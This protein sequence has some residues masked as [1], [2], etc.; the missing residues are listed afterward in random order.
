M[1]IA[2]ARYNSYTS[3]FSSAA[4]LSA[5]TFAEYQPRLENSLA[6]FCHAHAPSPFMLVKAETDFEHLTILQR[7]VE[8]LLPAG[9]LY[10]SRYHITPEQI[11]VTPAERPGDN[12]AAT[13]RVACAE[14]FES[15]QLLGTVRLG[16]S[17]LLLQP[18]L[19]HQANGGVLILSCVPC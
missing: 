18:G 3:V 9:D 17:G 19:V 6:Y 11:S 1:A 7:A 2:T 15:E 5:I 4:A 14:W 12:L 13:Q 10:G 16:K 8:A